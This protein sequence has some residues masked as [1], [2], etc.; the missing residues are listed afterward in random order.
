M[1]ILMKSCEVKTLNVP[2]S[3]VTLKVGFC[4]LLLII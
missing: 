3:A 4:V 1:R 2:P